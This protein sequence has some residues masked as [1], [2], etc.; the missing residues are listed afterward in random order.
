MEQGA[1]R[2][3]KG[4]KILELNGTSFEILVAGIIVENDS[5]AI[6]LEPD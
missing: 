3:I 4:K 5:D 1:G 2:F 6:S